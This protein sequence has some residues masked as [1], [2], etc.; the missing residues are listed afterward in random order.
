MKQGPE[1]VDLMEQ[2]RLRQ[3]DAGAASTSGMSSDMAAL[4][5]ILK[6][7]ND[8]NV[9]I[10]W[11]VEDPTAGHNGSVT[12]RA[13]STATS[14]LAVDALQY[15]QLRCVRYDSMMLFSEANTRTMTLH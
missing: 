12:F 7:V 9:V 11:S 4:N 13:T 2:L 1:P 15:Q 5:S 6:D 8:G 14:W 10:E 3:N